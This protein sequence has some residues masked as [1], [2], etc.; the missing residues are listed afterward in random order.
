MRT[1]LLQLSTRVCSTAEWQPMPQNCT[2]G[3]HCS[4]EQHCAGWVPPVL[5]TRVLPIS[6][7][8]SDWSDGTWRLILAS[9]SDRFHKRFPK[10]CQQPEHCCGLSLPTPPLVAQENSQ[11]QR[12]TFAHIYHQSTVISMNWLPT[13]LQLC[14]DVLY[15]K[16]GTFL[17][18][19]LQGTAQPSAVPL[20]MEPVPSGLAPNPSFAAAV[21]QGTS[22]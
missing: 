6:L 1:A 7:K 2:T 5:L 4:K 12:G 18:L 13:Q 16:Y 20:P 15:A 17:Q 10:H 19:A 11:E 9:W 14:K 21:D 8:D 3:T 22:G